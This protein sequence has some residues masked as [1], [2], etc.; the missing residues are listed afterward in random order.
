MHIL[1]WLL[2]TITI[3]TSFDKRNCEC[4]CGNLHRLDVFFQCCMHH[5]STFTY[6]VHMDFLNVFIL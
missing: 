3:Y 4:L 5:L 2:E 6:Y 1:E